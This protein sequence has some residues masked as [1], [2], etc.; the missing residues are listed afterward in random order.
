M[1]RGGHKGWVHNTLWHSFNVQ[2]IALAC[3]SA[4]YYQTVFCH[5]YHL[6]LWKFWHISCLNNL[7]SYGAVFLPAPIADYLQKNAHSPIPCWILHE[8]ML[9]VNEFNKKT[10]GHAI[11]HNRRA[12]H[13]GEPLNSVKK[14]VCWEVRCL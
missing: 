10:F 9:M 11:W 12:K 1:T 6:R 3:A 8:N 7:W 5:F 4:N 14:P 2:H 13:Y